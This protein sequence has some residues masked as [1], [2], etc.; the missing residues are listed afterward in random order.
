MSKP[1]M[2]GYFGVILRLRRGGGDRGEE[3]VCN[4]RRDIRKGVKGGR[5]R[6]R[7]RD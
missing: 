6:E 1:H 7:E 2:S 4:L 5:E 3:A